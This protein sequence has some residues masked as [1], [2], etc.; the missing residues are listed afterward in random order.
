M[1][2]SNLSNGTGLIQAQGIGSGIDIQ[3][4]VKQLVA[5]ESAPMETR[6]SRQA[7]RV[8]TEL[9]ALGTLKGALAT[10]QG[11]VSQLKDSAQFNALSAAS[12][13]PDL[14]TA[15]AG[16]AA[17]AGTYQLEVTQLAR[18]EQA[19]SKNY[20]GGAATVIGVGTL[21]LTVGTSSM[22]LEL[23]ASNN[24]LTAIR[25]QINAAS[26][27]PG[28]QATI[29]GDSS[30][31]RLVLTGRNSG[32]ANTFRVSATG[33]V[34][35]AQL[36]YS[37]A[38][39]AN[40]TNTESAQNATLKI[41]G[42][43]FS[44]ASNTVSEVLE[45]V[46]LNLK[47][48]EPGTV[49]TLTVATD[50]AT[51]IGNV[52]KFVDGYNSLQQRLKQLTGYDATTKTGGPMQGDP[53]AVG[54]AAE[55]RRLSFDSVAGLSGSVNSLAALGITSDSSGKLSLNET[56]LNAVLAQDRSAAA[57]LFG[58]SSQAVAGRLETAL[59]AKLA[60]NSTI[61]ARDQRLVADQKAIDVQRDQ[62]NRRMTA[63][64]NRYLTQF[65]ALDTLLAQMKQTSTYLTQQLA[66]SSSIANSSS[67]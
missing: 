20:G 1:A 46:T 39:D 63:V 12:S 13:Q 57:R 28:V 50:L 56:R 64:Q 36:A 23:T 34:G 22:N 58:G 49:G 55:L 18:V 65:N 67:G 47:D 35:I 41:A 31:A 45:G 51:I 17:T 19:V 3:S 10:F 32:A 43:S 16:S 66:A 11:V 21:T 4:L 37:G 54:I 25:D 26:N 61:A 9:S 5:A 27:N 6:L 14:F 52:R 62:H 7:A 48:A 60:S 40:W 30:G 8:G 29:I 38:V 15:S 42:V 33:D 59:I 24:T 2:V 53:M 44:S